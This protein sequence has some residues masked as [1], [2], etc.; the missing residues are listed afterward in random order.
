MAGTE[1]VFLERDLVRR[2][3]RLQAVAVKLRAKAAH[4]AIGVFLLR[5]A[6]APRCWLRSC[7]TAR[8][9][10]YV[11]GSWIWAWCTS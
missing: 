8:R 6:L 4:R 5:D 11:N 7:L 3:T 2:A 10:D 9:G 1:Q